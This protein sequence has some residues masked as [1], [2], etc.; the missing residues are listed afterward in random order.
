MKDHLKERSVSDYL[1]E[2]IKSMA[3]D[4]LDD[5]KRLDGAG[6]YVHMCTM[7]CWKNQTPYRV[8]SCFATDRRYVSFGDSIYDVCEGK[9]DGNGSPLLKRIL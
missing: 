6:M 9:N 5:Y 3:T 1:A 8:Y 2:D 4:Y 7:A